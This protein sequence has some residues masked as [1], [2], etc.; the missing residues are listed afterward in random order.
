MASVGLETA[1][2]PGNFPA[3]IGSEPDPRSPNAVNAL[4][5]EVGVNT[6]I[7]SFKIG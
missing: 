1:S 3:A 6:H 4:S 7:R 2:T 5:P